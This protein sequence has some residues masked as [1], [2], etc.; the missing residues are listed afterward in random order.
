M[1]V[2]TV[3]LALMTV[4]CCVAVG[5]MSACTT[6]TNGQPDRVPSAAST[7]LSSGPRPSSGAASSGPTSLATLDTCSLL[8]QEQL[9]KLGI[10]VD[11]TG[12]TSSVSRRCEWS[13]DNGALLLAVR[14]HQSL[15][16]FGVR[17]DHPIKELRIAGREAKQ[18]LGKRG[19][20]VVGV[21]VS[22]T[23]SF[24]AT[25]SLNDPDKQCSVARRVAKMVVPHLPGS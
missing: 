6:A 21:A 13:P 17:V 8:T 20:C 5:A 23:A 22:S 15:D 9:D 19:G 12:S 14:P 25:V 7:Q 24:D 16:R 2:R 18:Q 10:T 3:R 11:G 1:K 4:T